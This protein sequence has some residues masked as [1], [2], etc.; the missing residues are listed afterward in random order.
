MFNTNFIQLYLFLFE[1]WQHFAPEHLKYNGSNRRE[2]D[3]WYTQFFSVF[4]IKRNFKS[5]FVN[6]INNG[7]PYCNQALGLNEIIIYKKN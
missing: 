6:G 3:C 2:F 4:G 5:I 1:I 7:I